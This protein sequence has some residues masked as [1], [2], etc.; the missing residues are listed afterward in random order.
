MYTRVI[1]Y[2]AGEKGERRLR[3][4]SNSKRRP[5]ARE[6]SCFRTSARGNHTAEVLYYGEGANAYPKNVDE[7]LLKSMGRRAR[8]GG[9]NLA[10]R[11]VPQ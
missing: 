7:W 5:G 10:R 3:L 6:N 4:R 2:L 11:A 1:I 8:G 9:R